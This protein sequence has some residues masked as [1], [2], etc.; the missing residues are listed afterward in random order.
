MV[1]T[2]V[3]IEDGVVESDADAVPGFIAAFAGGKELATVADGTLA[4]GI[5]ASDPFVPTELPIAPLPA[6]DG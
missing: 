1:E 6:T 4:A 5:A 3:A 2:G